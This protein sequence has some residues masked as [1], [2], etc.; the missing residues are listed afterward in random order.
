MKRFFLLASL[1]CTLALNG[2]AWLPSFIWGND[3][4]FEPAISE[5]KYKPYPFAV[6]QEITAIQKIHFEYFGQHVPEEQRKTNFYA[7]FW[8]NSKTLKLAVLSE[9]HQRLWDIQFNGETIHE[10]RLAGLPDNL[11]AH[12]LLRDIAAALWPASHLQAQDKRFQVVDEQ[13]VRQIVNKETNA[14]E[15]TITYLDGANQNRP[16]GT[17]EIVNHQERYRVSITSNQAR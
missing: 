7:L 6:R 11:Q 15:V 14:P 8:A 5:L 17:I 2:C 16:W 13:L 1:A 10:E 4:T 9:M 3:K 12:L